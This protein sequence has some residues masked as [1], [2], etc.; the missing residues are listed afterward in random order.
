M[1]PDRVGILDWRAPRFVCAGRFIAA[2]RQLGVPVTTLD[3]VLNQRDGALHR[4]WRIGTTAGDTGESQ[5]PAMRDGGFVSIGW[6][7]VPNLSDIIGQDNAR[8]QIRNWLL[9]RSSNPSVASRN[10]GEISK[11]AQEIGEN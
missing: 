11:F 10:A 1:P 8:D 2:S 3:T 9:P 7:E 6:R 4:Y 5:W